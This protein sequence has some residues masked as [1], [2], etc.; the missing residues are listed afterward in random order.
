MALLHLEDYLDTIESLPG[1]L[2]R[3]F[4]LMRELD[5]RAQDAVANVENQTTQFMDDMR[6][7]SASE[8]VALLSQISQSFKDTLKHGEDKVALAV[9]T[10]DMVDR[11]IRRLDD[12]LNKFEEEQLTGPGLMRGGNTYGATR[13]E[14]GGSGSAGGAG[15]GR[16]EKRGASGMAADTPTKKYKKA[17]VT[18]NDDTPSRVNTTTNADIPKRNA[19]QTPKSSAANTKKISQT[20]NKKDKKTEIRTKDKPNVLDLPIDPN[21]P[22]YCICHQV[23]FGDMIECDN[24]DCPIE[25]FHYSCVGLTAPPKGKWFCPECGGVS[26]SLWC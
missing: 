7:M 8:R 12:D 14:K 13:G 11:H 9:Q 3:N 2:A 22:T 10:Y 21:E 4:T 17:R 1:E 19:S 6:T 23:S 25:W 16:G 26:P 5:A 20:S 15:A 18:N 24:E